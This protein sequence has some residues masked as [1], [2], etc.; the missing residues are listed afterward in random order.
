MSP[1]Q[2]FAEQGGMDWEDAYTLGQVLG[3]MSEDDQELLVTHFL[4]GHRMMEMGRIYGVHRR[5]IQARIHRALART[6]K[7]L[8]I[9]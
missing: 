6:R 5:T 9:S 4:L 7:A 3:V 2:E 8:G 1:E